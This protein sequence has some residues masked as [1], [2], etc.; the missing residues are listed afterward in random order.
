MKIDD[1]EPLFPSPKERIEQLNIFEDE[2]KKKKV[3]S[4]YD[5]EDT[6]AFLRM[7]MD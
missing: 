4:K 1:E 6:S 7:M 2:E 5:D 3:E